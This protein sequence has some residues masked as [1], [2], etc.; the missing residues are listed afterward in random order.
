M[1][2]R[3]ER[4]SEREQGRAGKRMKERG[5]ETETKREREIIP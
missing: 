4:A 1:E 3:S 2:G 5:K